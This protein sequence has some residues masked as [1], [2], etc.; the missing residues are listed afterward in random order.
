MPLAIRKPD[1]FEGQPPARFSYN[2]SDVER[3]AEFVGMP[4]QWPEP[5]PVVFRTDRPRKT[6][7]IQ[8]HIGRLSRLG[9]AAERRGQGLAFVGAVGRLLWAGGD[10][11]WDKGDRLNDALAQADL[12]LATLE[13]DVSADPAG[14]DLQIKMDGERLDSIGHWGVPTLAVRGEPFFGQ[15]R[16]DVF[17]WRLGQL[18][19]AG[20]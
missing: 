6:A 16:I 4:F 20:K 15:D 14:H 3:V 18:G 13:G 7:D 2:R 12:D 5:D 10:R 1:Y 8:P 17:E 11:P 9:I 19:I